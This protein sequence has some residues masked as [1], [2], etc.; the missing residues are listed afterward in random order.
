VAFVRDRQRRLQRQAQSSRT[1][2]W[3]DQQARYER[4]SEGLTEIKNQEPD[5]DPELAARGEGR[6]RN[7]CRE[8]SREQKAEAGRSE[9]AAQE[10]D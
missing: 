3:L 1:L 6:D 2:A 7:G 9:P 4:D 10:T 5:G 8:H